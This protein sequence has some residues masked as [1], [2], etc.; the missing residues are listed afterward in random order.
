MPYIKFVSL[1]IALLTFATRCALAQDLSGNFPSNLPAPPGQRPVP[2]IMRALDTDGDGVL[3][4]AE[5]ANAPTALKALD[6]NKDGKLDQVEIRPEFG[7]DGW[8]PS[9]GMRGMGGPGGPNNEMGRG[10]NPMTAEDELK[11][12]LTLDKNNDGKLTKDEVP[13][14]MQSLFTRADSDADGVQTK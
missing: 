10:E 7:S 6:K 8:N 2:P 9:R 3:S 12:Y 1:G 13:T 14:R 11:R 5:I 4:A